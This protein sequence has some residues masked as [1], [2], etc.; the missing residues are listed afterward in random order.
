MRLMMTLAFMISSIILL[1]ML[2]KR[3]PLRP[4][5]VHPGPHVTHVDAVAQNSERLAH[6]RQLELIYR[7]RLGGAITAVLLVLII[8]YRAGRRLG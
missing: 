4:E 1:V 2:P 7:V 6:Y 5:E 8:A 3:L